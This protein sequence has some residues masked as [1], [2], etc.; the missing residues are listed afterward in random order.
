MPFLKIICVNNDSKLTLG[1]EEILKGL[2]F[3]LTYDNP[4]FDP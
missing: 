4:Q 3:A 2:T 1:G